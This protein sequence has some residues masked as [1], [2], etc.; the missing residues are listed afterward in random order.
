MST[1]GL[2]IINNS[3]NKQ[4]RNLRCSSMCSNGMLTACE[5]RNFARFGGR[6]GGGNNKG[7]KDDYYQT[8][9]ID[10]NAS[11]A[12]IKKQYFQLAKKYHPDV[13]K[14]SDAKEKFAKINNAYETLSDENKRR[15]YD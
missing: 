15:I 6:G 1:R 3:L 8:L 2:F 12:D 5:K 10:R 13:N 4:F 7:G 11:Q 14:T 9:G